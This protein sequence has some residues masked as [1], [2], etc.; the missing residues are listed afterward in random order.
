[1]AMK[2]NV[3]VCNYNPMLVISVPVDSSTE[4]AYGDFAALSG[5]S[6]IAYNGD[7]SIFLGVVLEGHE[8]GEAGRVSVALEAVVEVPIASGGGN[9]Q[10]GDAYKRNAGANG[11]D[12][13]VAKATQEG[14][15]WALENK[16]AGSRCKFYLNALTKGGFLF[17]TITEG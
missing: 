6:A 9:A 10:I 5:G 12:W 1:M 3:R 15:L 11:T 16:T 2:S 14:F 8:A 7:N 17:D 4:L 13:N